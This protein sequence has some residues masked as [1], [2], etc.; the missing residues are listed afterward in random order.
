MTKIKIALPS[1]IP[2]E[3]PLGTCSLKRPLSVTTSTSMVGFPLLSKIWRART[4]LID[5]LWYRGCARDVRRRSELFQTKWWVFDFSRRTLSKSPRLSR[6]Q[7]SSPESLE[8]VFYLFVLLLSIDC[9]TIHANDCHS[10]LCCL[11]ND[12][13]FYLVTL[14]FLTCSNNFLALGSFRKCSLTG[15]IKSFKALA[16]AGFKSPGCN[17]PAS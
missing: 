8:V 14:N 6:F 10:I 9:T 1:W 12:P 5:I 13:L 3:A 17:W 4:L 7:R 2:V 11:S 16:K 15:L